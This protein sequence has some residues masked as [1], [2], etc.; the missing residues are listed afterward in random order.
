MPPARLRQA[1]TRACQEVPDQLGDFVQRGI[2]QEVPAVEQ[3]DLGSGRSSANAS[4]PAGPKISSPRP[5]TAS[6]GTR[7]ARKYSCTRGYIGALVA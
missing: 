4:A 1:G 2:Q 7:L 6:S 5:H 3:V